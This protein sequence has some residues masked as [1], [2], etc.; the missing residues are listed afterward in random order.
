MLKRKGGTQVDKQLENI[1]N[2][3]IKKQLEKMGVFIESSFY[4]N[5]DYDWISLAKAE[6]IAKM[7][8]Y[9]DYINRYFGDILS[10]VKIVEVLFPLEKNNIENPNKQELLEYFL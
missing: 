5:G 1:I 8:K 4:T 2:R 6:N 3:K 10:D 9:A 7:K